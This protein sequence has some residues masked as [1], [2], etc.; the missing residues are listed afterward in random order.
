MDSLAARWAE[1]TA[2]LD[3]TFWTLLGAILVLDGIAMHG[4]TYIANHVSR[5]RVRP[6]QQPP[7]P[8]M[9]RVVNTNLNNLLSL[10]VWATYFYFLGERTLYVA[11]PASFATLLYEVFTV[12]LLYDFM[13][14]IFHR[15]MHYPKLMPY[16]HGVHHR[17]R[18]PTSDQSTYLHPLE[19]IGGVGLVIAALAV[20][21]PISKASF[22]TMFA[23]HSTV[24]IIVHS[25]LRI[26]HPA[27]WLFNFWVQ[28]HDVHHF[29]LRNNYASIFPFWDMALGTYE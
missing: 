6:P 1:H 9:L 10:V 29:R 8:L 14:Y 28:K 4:L 27:F 13:Y 3:R 16:C 7:I 23:I 5:L 21:G 2:N 19:T 12:L 11:R 26:P 22:L 20:L 25:N 15:V 17:V 24:N 18:S